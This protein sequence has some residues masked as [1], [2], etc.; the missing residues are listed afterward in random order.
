[1]GRAREIST[2][3]TSGLLINERAE[4]PAPLE[5]PAPTPDVGELRVFYPTIS[6]FGIVKEAPVKARSEGEAR[7]ILL[8]L[9][10][11]AIQ[12]PKAVKGEL[13]NSEYIVHAYV[14]M[15]KLDPKKADVQELATKLRISYAD[16]KAALKTM[17][18]HAPRKGF[19]PGDDPAGAPTYGGMPSTWASEA[20]AKRG[21]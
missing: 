20:I 11:R 2:A 9:F 3:V 15:N 6:I 5:P 16:V 8:D 21:G 13:P 12:F 1:M 7:Q 17:P 18:S 10:S 19:E 4:T 14:R